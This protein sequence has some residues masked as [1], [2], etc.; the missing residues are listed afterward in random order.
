MLADASLH[1]AVAAGAR[2]TFRAL[3]ESEAVVHGTELDH[4]H[5]HEVGAVDAI[6]DIVGCWAAL[7]SL[8]VDEVV[9]APIGLGWGSEAMAHGRVPVPAPAVLELLVGIPTVP[10]DAPAETATPTGVALLVSMVDRWGPPPPGTLVATPMLT[11]QPG[12]ARACSTPARMRSATTNASSRTVSGSSA[13]NSFNSMVPFPSESTV[14]TIAR[15]SAEVTRSPRGTPTSPANCSLP[16]LPA[17][18]R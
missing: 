15:S 18:A 11:V 9:S 4:V 12:C 2:R 3:G 1:P 13:T 10:V 6:V 5:F 14:L 17:T 7:V 16:T 8:R